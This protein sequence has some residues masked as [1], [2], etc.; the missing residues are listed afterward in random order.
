M[1]TEFTPDGQVRRDGPAASKYRMSTHWSTYVILAL[2]AVVI[3]SGLVLTLRDDESA[4]N[5]TQL[6]NATQSAPTPEK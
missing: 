4:S 3:V 2:F 5:T 1:A 6:T